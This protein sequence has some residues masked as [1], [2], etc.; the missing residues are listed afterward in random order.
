MATHPAEIA[1][2]ILAEW[3][4]EMVPLVTN[5]I[6]SSFDP[7]WGSGAPTREQIEYYLTFLY[8]P[9]RVTPNPVGREALK[10][11][12]DPLYPQAGVL[13]PGAAQLY[14]QVCTAVRNELRRE[15]R[16]LEEVA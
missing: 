9:D 15:R 3:R 2:R 13:S 12:F 14:S 7:P 4:A 11:R 5:G 6:L 10:A 16:E 8:L 1:S